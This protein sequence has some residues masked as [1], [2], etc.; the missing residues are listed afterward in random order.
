MG[1]ELQAGAEKIPA[2][3]PSHLACAALRSVSCLPARRRQ[4]FTLNLKSN[5]LCRIPGWTG[6]TIPAFVS[7]NILFP[8]SIKTVACSELFVPLNWEA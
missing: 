1:E 5:R 7:Q 8:L 3:A 6:H 4:A 2:R